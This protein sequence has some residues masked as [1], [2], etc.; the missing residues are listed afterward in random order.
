MKIKILWFFDLRPLSRL[1]SSKKTPSEL[2]DCY[3]RILSLKI[4]ETGWIQLVRRSWGWRQGRVSSDF[5]TNQ[6]PWQQSTYCNSASLVRNQTLNFHFAFRL[7]RSA[8]DEQKGWP[9][10]CKGLAVILHDNFTV[11]PIHKVTWKTHQPKAE[12][13][14]RW[15]Q[16]LCSSHHSPTHVWSTPSTKSYVE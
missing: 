9:D 15:Y 16:N 13:E 7:V 2:R 4:W 1:Q 3:I 14:D 10:L 12:S 8:L 11:S 6:D 5:E